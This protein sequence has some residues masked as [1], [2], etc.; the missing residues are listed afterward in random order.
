MPT[1]EEDMDHATAIRRLYDLVNA[2]DIDGFGSYLTEESV[3]RKDLPAFPNP[4][5]ESAAIN[6]AAA[7]WRD[8]Q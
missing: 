6:A 7:V 5:R 8:A 4:I 1:W 3:K 2:G